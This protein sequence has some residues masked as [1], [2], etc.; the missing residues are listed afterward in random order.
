MLEPK[1]ESRPTIWQVCEAAFRI[2]GHHNPVQNVFVSQCHYYTDYYYYN[3]M[4]MCIYLVCV[5][6]VSCEHLFL[7]FKMISELAV[8]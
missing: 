7:A 5:Y 2:T 1:A 8:F 4:Y 6:I 3:N